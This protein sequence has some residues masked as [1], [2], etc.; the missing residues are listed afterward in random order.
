[1]P[2]VGFK[3][4]EESKIK[5]REA[6]LKNPQGFK[7]GN[8]INLGRKYSEERRNNISLSKQGKPLKTAGWNKG[9]QLPLEWRKKLSLA[10]QGKWSKSNNPNWRGGVTKINES[11]RNSMMYRFWRDSVF[12]R[13]MYCCQECGIKSGCGYKVVF[14]AHH[15]K[16]YSTHPE[17]R[18]AIDNGIT[19]C[20]TCHQKTETYGG[21]YMKSIREGMA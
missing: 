2:K 15:I 14:N 17:L 13:D 20:V 19:L 12:K 4:S 6:R 11:T 21:K 9:M 3:H 10:K 18:F 16:P 5:M 1:M 8:T 7:V